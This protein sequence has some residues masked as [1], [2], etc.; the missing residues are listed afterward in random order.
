[1]IQRARFRE[2]TNQGIHFNHKSTVSTETINLLSAL[3]PLWALWLRGQADIIAWQC[4]PLVANTEKR[5]SRA[6]P[7]ALRP[8]PFKVVVCPQRFV[9]D[10]HYYVASI[11]YDP[12]AVL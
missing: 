5:S 6:V 11:D 2:R 7:R 4:D 9:E 8:E 12:L 1:M 10:M 3:C